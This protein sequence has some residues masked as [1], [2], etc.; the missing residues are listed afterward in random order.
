[1]SKVRAFLVS[2]FVSIFSVVIYAPPF[3]GMDL[4]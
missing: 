4:L 2:A 1:M 3:L